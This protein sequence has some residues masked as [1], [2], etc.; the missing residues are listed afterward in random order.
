MV[1]YLDCSPE[2]VKQR[3]RLNSGGDRSDRIDDSMKEIENKMDIFHKRTSPLLQYYQNK[4][5]PVKKITVGINTSPED[6]LY[7]FDIYGFNI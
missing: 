6:I 5:I 1:V 3:I 7:G 4:N 2:T